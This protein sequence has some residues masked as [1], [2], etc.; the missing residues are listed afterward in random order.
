MI[1]NTQ[2]NYFTKYTSKAQEVFS[3][4]TFTDAVKKFVNEN[5]S[6][7]DL[8]YLDFNNS[9]TELLDD[10]KEPIFFNERVKKNSH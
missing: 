2:G 9:Q 6:Q 3:S 4:A 8:R 7:F 1:N 10:N 5:L